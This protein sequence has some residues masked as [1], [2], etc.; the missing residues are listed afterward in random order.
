MAHFLCS[1]EDY[2]R[3]KNVKRLIAYKIIEMTKHINVTTFPAL[4]V[5]TL[6]DELTARLH[7]VFQYRVNHMI[8]DKLRKLF[9]ITSYNKNRSLT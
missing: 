7:E 8:T 5:K 4:R 1:Y 6:V 3:H 2:E 9:V